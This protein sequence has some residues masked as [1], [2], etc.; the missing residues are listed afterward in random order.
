MEH[1]FAI[2]YKKGK[3]KLVADVRSR[4]LK[5]QDKIDGTLAMISFLCPD[6]VEESKTTYNLSPELK[7]IMDKL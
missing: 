1:D 4:K 3:E 7:E 2:H 6:W 5:V